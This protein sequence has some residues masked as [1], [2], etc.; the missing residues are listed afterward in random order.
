MLE[1]D[2]PQG[3]FA[4]YAESVMRERVL[5]GLKQ[6]SSCGI[7]G[8]QFDIERIWD[9]DSTDVPHGTA[10]LLANMPVNEDED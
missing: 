5:A 3:R 2:L 6:L 4:P 7:L 10:S 1:G 8:L 9:P